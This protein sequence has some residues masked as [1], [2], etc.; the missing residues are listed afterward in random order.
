MKRTITVSYEV[1]YD[2]PCINEHVNQLTRALNDHGFDY[3]IYVYFEKEEPN[4]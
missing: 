2:D 1:D 4:A 3:N